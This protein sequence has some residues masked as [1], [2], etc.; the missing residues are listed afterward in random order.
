MGNVR[1]WY[2]YG[3]CAIALQA[4]AWALIN[5]LRNLLLS[6]LRPQPEALAFQIAVI[7]VG[8]ALYL[9]HWLWARR[10]TRASDE[11]RHATLRGLYLYGMMAGFLGPI[12]PNLYDLLRTLMGTKRVWSGYPRV[13][14]TPREWSVYHLMAVL[15]LGLWWLYHWMEV[16]QEGKRESDGWATVRRSYILGFSAAGLKITTVAMIS[17]IQWLLLLPGAI[18]SRGAASQSVLTLGAQLLIGVPLW[19]VFWSRA[20]ALFDAGNASERDSALRKA[21]LYLAALIGS[22]GSIY[23]AAALAASLMRRLLGWSAV[24]QGSEGDYRQALSIIAGL[25]VLWSYHAYVLRGDAAKE[26]T[27]AQKATVRHIYIY[28]VAGAGLLALGIGLGGEVTVLVNT[29][30]S[31][32]FGNSQQAAFAWATA[33]I[34]AGLPVH[35]VQRRRAQLEARGTGPDSTHA[36]R[37]VPRRIYLYLFLFAAAL[38]DLGALV[39]IVYKILSALLGGEPLRMA[40]IAQYIGYAAIGAAVWVS[41]LVVLRSDRQ[42]LA[43]TEEAKAL[44]LVMLDAEGSSLGPAIVRALAESVGGVDVTLAQVG[45]AGTADDSAEAARDELLGAADLVQVPW[46]LLQAGSGVPASLPGAV[47]RSPVRKLLLPI[48]SEGWEW[49]GVDRWEPDEWA[50]EAVNA[51][52]RAVEGRPIKPR[53]PLGA[54]AIA[55][56][57]LGGL[58]LL[59]ALGAAIANIL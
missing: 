20:Q 13:E 22:M 59:S 26:E 25:G 45:Q 44:R 2:T 32:G 15:V 23:A 38:V 17:L 53:R 49:V 19:T 37:S 3:I 12:L 14:L 6:P 21:Y 18:W 31:G 9:G 33:A 7:V 40:E 47:A 34:I 56:I 10:L 57:V 54:A 1:R 11:E 55:W 24:A 39:F 36:L 42:L 8:G 35:V 41:H 46:L 16:R 43:A 50:R 29:L 4:L 52:G 58:M 30:A 51:V 28:L 27:T 5:L 48:W